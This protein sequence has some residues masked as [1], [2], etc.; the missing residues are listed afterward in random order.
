MLSAGMWKFM[1]RAVSQSSP[2]G[3]TELCRWQEEG[4]GCSYC[5]SHAWVPA[6]SRAGPLPGHLLP[7]AHTHL[8]HGPDRIFPPLLSSDICPLRAARA[9]PGLCTAHSCWPTYQTVPR[10]VFN[11]AE[12]TGGT[13]SHFHA[14]VIV[15]TAQEVGLSP[16]HFRDG[17][18]EAQRR[19]NPPRSPS[20]WDG[21][22]AV[23]VPLSCVR[24]VS[25]GA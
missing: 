22:G 23:M 15:L 4:K 6:N 13:P 10:C 1:P 17:E 9:D 24:P 16:T 5:S 8:C 19:R 3:P 12:R 2:S 20:R 14:P 18:A 21:A 25:C 7:G 11:Q